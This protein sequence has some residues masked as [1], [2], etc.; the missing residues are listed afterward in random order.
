M[1]IQFN[2][3]CIAAMLFF[4]AHPDLRAE[5]FTYVD[6]ASGVTLMSNVSPTV[7]QQ[8]ENSKR[9]SNHGR[10]SQAGS[11]V[12]PV[13]FPTVSP[14]TQK[15]R[16]NDRRAILRKELENEQR[17]ADVALVRQ[18]PVSVL[19]RHF[20]NIAALKRELGALPP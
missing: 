13:N 12:R 16:D 17:S 11:A 19:H 3:S 18:E 1:R 2:H 14:Q 4:C 15:E 7:N 10:V 5:I 8:I 6:P 20:E 9:I